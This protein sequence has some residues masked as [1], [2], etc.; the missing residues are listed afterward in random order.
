MR[1][2]GRLYICSYI[3]RPR[4]VKYFD[5]FDAIKCPAMILLRL[6]VRNLHAMNRLTYIDSCLLLIHLI[7]CNAMHRSI[8]WGQSIKL[9]TFY[10]KLATAAK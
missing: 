10:K 4:D 9:F 8:I 1:C 2:K 3:I 5:H 7:L 6:Y